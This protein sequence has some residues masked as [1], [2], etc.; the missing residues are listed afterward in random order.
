MD[1]RGGFADGVMDLRKQLYPKTQPRLAEEPVVG[2]MVRLYR[3][4]AAQ[5]PASA[6][7]VVLLT[8]LGDSRAAPVIARELAITVALKLERRAL[9]LD[10]TPSAS[11]LSRFNVFPNYSWIKAYRDQKPISDTVYQLGDTLLHV[12]QLA[13]DRD[14]LVEVIDAPQTGGH[15]IS[16]KTAFELTVIDSVPSPGTDQR[17]AAITQEGGIA[18]AAMADGALVVIESEKTRWQAAAKL[19]GDIENRGGRVLGTVL[20]NRRHHIPK[21]LYDR[22]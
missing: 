7:R 17:S 21:F 1:G 14:D 16:L 11:Q 12:S 3:T 4:L 13:R 5:T 10:A 8:G 6:G 2:K 18:L 15:L 22:L 19:V 9:L 20:S